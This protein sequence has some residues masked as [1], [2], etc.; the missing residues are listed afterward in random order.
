MDTRNLI[1]YVGELINVTEGLC[2]SPNL[3]T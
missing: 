3:W 1:V 2:G